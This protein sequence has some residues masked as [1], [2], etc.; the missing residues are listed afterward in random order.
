MS[1]AKDIRSQIKSIKSTQKITKAM[2][3][4]AA[5][6]MRR[7]QDAMLEGR[8]YVENILRVIAHL[9]KAHGETP[10]PFFDETRDNVKK[11]GYI[12][13]STDRGLCGGLNINQFK[14]LL[15]HVQEWNNKGCEIDFSVFGRKG[16]A[17]INRINGHIMTSVDAYGDNPPLRDL[18]GGISS[19]IDAYRAGEI[20]RVYLV[21]NRFVNTMTQEPNIVQFLPATIVVNDK[22]VPKHAWTYEYEPGVE[23]ILDKLAVRYLESVVKQAVA[24]NIACEMSA[25]MIAM[26]NASD[27]AANLIGELEL[28]YNKARQA[29]ITQELTE[30]VGGAAAV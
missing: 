18:I 9:L 26:K 13:I 10:H 25:R 14:A 28:Q 11:V 22:Y 24:E 2:Q 7:S 5:S 19:M 20:D 21:S 29:A 3:M 17:F 1:N 4:V 12:V 30:I 8:P 15:A 16:I 23:Q 27:N 6:K